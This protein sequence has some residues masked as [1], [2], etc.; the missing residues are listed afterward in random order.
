MGIQAEGQGGSLDVHWA[1]AGE[2]FDIR[3]IA[4]LGSGTTRLKGD[5]QLVEAVLPNGEKVS[6][7]PAELLARGFGVDIPVDALSFWVRGIAYGGDYRGASWDENGDLFEIRQR[8]WRVEMSRYQ[9]VAAYRLP[10]RFYLEQ[11]RNEDINVRF[12]VRAWTALAP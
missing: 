11:E 1:R 6:G 2:E 3:L 9:E 4:P 8:G 12:I 7:T 5:D 10:T